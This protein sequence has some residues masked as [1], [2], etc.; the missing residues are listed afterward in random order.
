MRPAA[1]NLDPGLVA[2]TLDR[3]V[4][5]A[6]QEGVVVSTRSGGLRMVNKAAERILGLNRIQL[7]FGEPPPAG[8]AM[9]EEDGV[10][11]IRI[12]P[13]TE[14][15]TSGLPIDGRVG[16][17]RHADGSLTW[18]RMSGQPLHTS[19]GAPDGVV[20][21][22]VD[23]TEERRLAAHALDE[24]RLR[25]LDQRLNEIEMIVGIDGTIVHVNDRALEAYGYARD[26][27]IGRSI[28][29]LRA[30]DTMGAVAGQ[31]QRAIEGGI[32]F[33]TVHRRADGSTF[34]VEV[35][36]RG[37]EV[38]GVRYLHSLVRDLTAQKTADADRQAL[39]EQIA[40][41]LRDRNLILETSPLGICKAVRRHLAW[42]NRRMEEMFGHPP[43]GMAGIST[44]DIYASEEAWLALGEVAYPI[45]A[46]GLTYVADLEFMRLDGTRFWG[47]LAGRAM[48]PEDVRAET[49]WTLEDIT[50]TREY[51]QRIAESEERL[52]SIVTAMAEG[53]V[54]QDP[55]GA[56]VMANAAAARILGMTEDQLEG[57]T[58][59]DPGWRSIHEDGHPF[60]GEDHPA[61]V[62]LRTG[63]PQ[64]GAIMGV[65]TP[66]NVVRWI[67]TSSEPMRHAPDEAPYAVVSTFTDITDLR[68][69]REALERSER[70]YRKL[71]DS[72]REAVIVFDVLRNRQGVVVDWR[73][74]EANAGGRRYLGAAYPF[75]IFRPI[76]ELLGD[77]EMRPHVMATDQLLAGRDGDRGIEF[78]APGGRF[79]GT[80]FA[81]DDDTIVAVGPELAPRT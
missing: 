79:K 32:R 66:D 75:S 76:G 67:S 37:F 14:V 31:M 27:M 33:E 77:A 55:S 48:H 70:R 26:E 52:R 29:D 69:G 5:G 74:R 16:A 81:I 36:S 43:G 46:G 68:R 17:V 64:V 7:E 73:L 72:L 44:H 28:R 57:K 34:P 51:E 63:E 62:T 39:E 4:I 8:W 49:V 13:G 40:A 38:G 80:A 11:P 50:G 18:V 45:M 12:H 22:F 10:T 21:T 58:S 71:F 78:M 30:P 19:G 42:T 47:R 60:P 9:L 41:G 25:S 65:G 23:I 54:V 56:I 35:S 3:L 59:M 2:E 61:M 6:M 20:M 53:V 15:M 1:E 24:A